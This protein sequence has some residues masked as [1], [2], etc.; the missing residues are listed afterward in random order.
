MQ[1]SRYLG[2]WIDSEGLVPLSDGRLT[3]LREPLAGLSECLFRLA[4]LLGRAGPGVQP[5][6]RLS[7]SLLPDADDLRQLTTDARPQGIHPGLSQ[8]DLGGPQVGPACGLSLHLLL[9]DFEQR[10]QFADGVP[11]VDLG[12]V[13][14]PVQFRDLGP[15]ALVLDRKPAVLRVRDSLP[16]V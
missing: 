14:L 7:Q 16:T 13:V 10:F 6:L 15:Q 8:R 11:K 3:R 2:L 1:G 4:D 9:H 12:Q 5:G